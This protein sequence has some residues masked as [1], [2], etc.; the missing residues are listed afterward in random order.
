MDASFLLVWGGL[1]AAPIVAIVVFVSIKRK[2]PKAQ[3]VV[4]RSAVAALLVIACSF[5]LGISFTAAPINC[6][7]LAIAYLAFCYLAVSCWLIPNKVFRV[8]ALIGF[9]MPIVIGYFVVTVGFLGLA[10]SVG[11]SGNVPLHTE[12]VRT[13]L[14]CRIIPWGMAF[15]DSGYT[16]HLY[17]HWAAVPFLEREVEKI[18]INQSEPGAG[19]ITVTCHDALLAHIK[20]SNS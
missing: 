10:F 2:F 9:A 7:C 4:A 1:L 11:D 5:V 8:F 13:D 14:V 15:T 16:V 18:V 20:S 19:S 12:N 6:V 17:K 3:A